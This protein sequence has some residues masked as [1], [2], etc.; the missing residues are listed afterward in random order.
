MPTEAT[1]APL[2]FGIDFGTDSVRALLLD[3]LSGDTVAASEARYPR[4]AEGRYCDPSA[5]QY[6]QHPLDGIEAMT[7]AVRGCLD[8]ASSAAPR[9]AGLSVDATGSTPCLTDAE[10]TPLALTPGFEDDPDAMFI[11]W[12]D[13]TATEEAARIN[14]VAEG[15]EYL[16]DVGGIYSSEWALAKAAHVLGK[17]GEAGAAA[18]GFVEHCD[19]VPALLTGTPAPGR[20]RRSRCAAGHKALWSARWGGLPPED[21]LARVHPGLAAMRDGFGAET[22]TTDRAVG[23]LT[24]EWATILGLPSTVVV[25]V[26]ALDA[27]VGAVGAQVG[28]GALARI[29]GTSTCDIMVAP[30]GVLGGHTIPG[31]CGQVDGSVVP[32][33]IGLEAGQSAFGDLYAW[34]ARFLSAPVL[35]V[36]DEAADRTAA[37]DAL[38]VRLIEHLARVAQSRDPGTRD[39]V[40]LDWIN[41]RRTPDAD[42]TLT[43]A[44]SGLDMG[45]DAADVFA[46]LV[47]ATCFGARAI[48]DRLRASGVAVDEVIALGGVAQKS[49]YVMQTMAD[50]M[51][52]PIKVSA[53]DEACAL[54]AGM[55]ASVAA[56][57]HADIA[58]AQA[59]MGQGWQRTF[60]P[61]AGRG[62]IFDARYTERYLPLGAFEEGRTR[63]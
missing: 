5:H 24:D 57:V 15:T 26:G 43:A 2:V 20:L 8:Q 59:A 38:D 16:R 6:R 35:A 51:G 21:F 46:A 25:G 30:Q 28:P 31:I 56:G 34:F 37:T 50:V 63:R 33:M 45:T 44:I 1:G 3:A 36:L 32:G 60:T 22:W 11:L 48:L 54:G 42:Q 47:E 9:V 39:V 18:R 52:M 41:G 58:S 62:A 17:D 19:Y 27:H 29:I 10:G 14:A 40:A 53:A 4:W 49:P 23:T 61:D 7:A 12:K 55:F 13:H